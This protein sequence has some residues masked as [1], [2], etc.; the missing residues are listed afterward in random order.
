MKEATAEFEKVLKIEPKF[1]P[2]IYFFLASGTR[3][4]GIATGQWLLWKKG[5]AESLGMSKC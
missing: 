3:N 4:R 5:F 2:D 1:D